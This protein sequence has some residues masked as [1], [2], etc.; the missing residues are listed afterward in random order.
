MEQLVRSGLMPDSFMGPG[1]DIKAQALL[2]WDMIK[3]PLV[4]PLLRVAV[5]VCLMVSLMLFCERVYMS[6][7]I[8]LV[9]LFGRKPDKRYKFEPFR[10]DVESGNSDYPHVLIQIPMFNEREVYKMSI[11][12]ACKLS[13]PS[14]RVV[15]QVLDDSTDH[16]V[17][18]M[19]QIECQ[20]WAN[21]G[22]NIRYQVRDNRKGYKSGALKDGLTHQYV[23]DCEY[24]A[25]FDADFQPDPDFLL[26]SIPYLSLN[27]EIALVQARWVFVNSDEC[28]LT[29]MQEMSLDYH[30]TVEQEVGSS[31]HAFFGFNGTAG[32]WR[33]AAINEAG[34]WKDR[35]TVED[36]DLAVRA[37]LR[38]WK[39]LY[40][41]DL[42]V[43]SELPSTFQAFRFQ[44][45]RWSCGP[46]NLFRKMFMEII[47]NKTVT[48]YKKVYVIY[49]FFL[50]R[51][52]IA[53]IITF[54][55]YCLI[56]PATCWIPEVVIPKWGAV[57]IPVI[58]TV[59]N[60]AGTPR[61]M[62][63]LMFWI[64][65]ENV[66]SLH[67][68]KATLIGLFETGR[69]N[70]WVVTEKLGD[71]TK[72]SPRKAPKRPRFRLGSRLHMLE[73]GVSAYLFASACYDYS[74]GNTRFFIYLYIQSMAF[75]IMGCGYV[76]TI[77]PSS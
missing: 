54:S 42:Q 29:R 20:K 61:S 35:T 44:Q 40:L 72:K 43:K 50:I 32:V 23:K 25:I 24:V 47:R 13:W 59:L 11:G 1:D 37:G 51:K 71:A 15:I 33:I 38:G 16:T 28:M 56:I 63:L 60:A 8:V 22:I 2:I 58:I 66:M 27:P 45:H 68:T 46:A 21:K 18:Q 53:H 4:V 41:G 76:G 49:N 30:F 70:E 5:V 10:D 55:F 14:D 75:L 62:H 34:G 73:L 7:V 52:I 31:T 77:V 69:A 64:L 57:Y 6:I 19:V 17:K 3:A 48:W 36:M 9:K 39:F 26:R 65:F 74:Y 12:A 67:R